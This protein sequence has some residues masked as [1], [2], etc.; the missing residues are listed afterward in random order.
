[1]QLN[2]NYITDLKKFMARAKKALKHDLLLL[3]GDFCETAAI[4]LYPESRPS[5]Q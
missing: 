3:L 2:G 5:N 1:M 4:Q